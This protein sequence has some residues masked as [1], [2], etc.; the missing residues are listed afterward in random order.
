MYAKTEYEIGSQK[1]HANPYHLLAYHQ[2]ISIEAKKNFCT[3]KKSHKSYLKSQIKSHANRSLTCFGSFWLQQID[4]NFFPSF[5]FII[6]FFFSCKL[7]W[8]CERLKIIKILRKVKSPNGPKSSYIKTKFYRKYCHTIQI[9]RTN[10]KI[11]YDLCIMR[12]EK[13]NNNSSNGKRKQKPTKNSIHHKMHEMRH[14]DLIYTELMI[15]R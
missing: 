13:K 15:N 5:V 12:I 4:L 8:K 10:T 14:F 1:C 11:T 6:G 2:I 9:L 3:R 7:H